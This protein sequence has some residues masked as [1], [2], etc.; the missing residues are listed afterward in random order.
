MPSNVA[1]SP[2]TSFKL[3]VHTLPFLPSSFDGSVKRNVTDGSGLRVKS[4]RAEEALRTVDVSERGVSTPSSWTAQVQSRAAAR[5]KEGSRRALVAGVI[6]VVLDSVVLTV[7]V[8]R[9]LQ[10]GKCFLTGQ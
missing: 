5:Y 8:T 6:W 9:F 3:Y 1:E 4:V 2:G 10:R 7:L